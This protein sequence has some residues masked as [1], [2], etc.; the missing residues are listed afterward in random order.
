MTDI[1]YCKH[2]RQEFFVRLPEKFSGD[3]LLVCPNELCRWQHYRHF[4][5]GEAIHCNI[6]RRHED[7]TII[8][9]SY[10]RTYHA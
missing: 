9:G 2:C 3:V 4:H 10:S 6:S 8:N 5:N 7:P 1:H